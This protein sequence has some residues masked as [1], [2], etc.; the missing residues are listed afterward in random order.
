MTDDIRPFR[1]VLL[2]LFFLTVGMEVIPSIVAVGALPRNRYVARFQLSS[3]D[4]LA[5]CS[6]PGSAVPHPSRTPHRDFVHW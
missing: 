2:G 4:R 5:A 6:G 3:R 1:D